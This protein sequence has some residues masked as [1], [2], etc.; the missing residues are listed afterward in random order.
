M[1]D[2]KPFSL[3][4]VKGASRGQVLRT[5]KRR[6]SV[7]SAKENDLVVADPQISPR[8]FL[9]LIDQGRWRIHTF[10]PENSI[11]VDRRWSHP[12]TGERGALITAN[13][14]ELLLYPGALEDRIIEREI[15]RR[16]DDTAPI[17]EVA[18]ADRA[19]VTMIGE[20]PVEFRTNELPEPDST[21]G[22]DMSSLPTVAGER[23]PDQIRAAARN[24]MAE[25]RAKSELTSLPKIAPWEQQ[26]AGL[27]WKNGQPVMKPFRA[28]AQVMEDAPPTEPHPAV[29]DPSI[30][31]VIPEPESRVMR[32]PGST[33]SMMSFR[34]GTETG[35]MMPNSG[36]GPK[37]AW[38]DSKKDALPKEPVRES[39][40]E[41]T[42]EAR[43]QPKDNAKSVNAWG[44]ASARKPRAQ[45]VI[46]ETPPV[47]ER[48]PRTNAWGDPANRGSAGSGQFE[49]VRSNE[50]S[51]SNG[52]SVPAVRPNAPV[53]RI[54]AIDE[55]ARK[56]EAALTIL[57][58]P[59]GEL[60]TSVRLLGTRL[61]EAMKTFGYRAY[62]VTSPEP[63]TGKTTTAAN[64]ALALAEDSQRRIA[65]IEANF[66]YPRFA[67]IFGTPEDYGLIPLLEG[68]VQLNEAIAKIADRNLVIL[69]AGG[70][71]ANPAELL[72]SPRFK[73]LVA[74]LANT[75]DMAI[76]DAPS[77]SPFADANILLP[78][79]DAAL[80]VVSENSTN[81]GWI[82]R[83]QKQLGE[84]RILGAVYNSIPKRTKKEMKPEL[85]ER[86]RQIRSS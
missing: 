2:A 15:A 27:E 21:Q 50:P 39:V 73:A 38:G 69:P 81:V 56:K 59:D 37:N 84:A 66:R 85:K 44:D 20:R 79:V 36:S 53:G 29:S 30:P 62:M 23:L 61:Q 67:E 19:L 1:S 49:G 35:S 32:M 34:P 74:E 41:P 55:L 70:R 11:T 54:L 31:E 25:E 52:R 5:D 43:P 33:K 78:L 63:L 47:R 14:V 24:R 26:T 58:E 7:G 42:R 65:L 82:G 22:I 3:A 18:E 8:H 45:A 57:S 64:L 72:A 68:Q 76:I 6:I 83:A 40:R 60:S 9:V 10:S 17:E 4:V 13:R 75:V 46:P 51:R 28:R 77:V 48:E 12:L 80:L 16:N 86:M 71:H